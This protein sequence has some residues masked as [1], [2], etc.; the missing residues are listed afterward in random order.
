[1]LQGLQQQGL[2]TK[3]AQGYQLTFSLKKGQAQLN[4]NPMPLPTGQ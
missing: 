2:L 1:M 4:G 3:T